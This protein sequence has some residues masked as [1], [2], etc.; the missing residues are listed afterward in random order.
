MKLVSFSKIG[1]SPFGSNSSSTDYK[2]G[3]RYHFEDKLVG[4]I[5][6]FQNILI[7]ILSGFFSFFN[8]DLLSYLA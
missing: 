5:Q 3:G 2:Y 8:F 6:D 1:S 4:V 7:P